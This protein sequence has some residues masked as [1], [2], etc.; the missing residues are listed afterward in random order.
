MRE[1][2]SC[3]RYGL[4]EPKWSYLVI[5]V[6]V[7]SLLCQPVGVEGQS[8]AHLSVSISGQSLTAGFN[9]TVTISIVNNYSGYIAI[10]DVDIAISVPSTLAAYG[11]NHWHYN[12]IAYGQ[13][14]TVNLEV[15][16][17]TSTIG[18]SSLGTVTA[19]YKQLGD[20]SYT[21][22]VHDIGFAVTGWISLVIYGIQLTPT[23]TVEGGNTTISGNLLNAGNLAAY[24]ANVTVESDILAPGYPTSVFIGEIDPNI[25]RPFSLLVLFKQNV[26]DGNYTLTVRVAATDNNR[27]G[28]P[29]SGQANSQIQ[30]SRASAATGQRLT[31]G[32]TGLLGEIIGILR[33]LFNAF[34]G[35]SY[36]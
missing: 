3:R 33:N 4:T 16:A 19:T 24:N 12:S 14:V 36:P 2:G 13:T 9:N 32:P 35:A 31:R 21:Q 8:A 20:V 5:A 15:Y 26:Q 10:Y 27:P 23:V 17:P 22:E 25:P 34:F 1:Y 28:I 6:L 29:L 11:D 7:V 30:I 18:T